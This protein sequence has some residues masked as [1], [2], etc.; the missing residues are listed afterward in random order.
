MP[1]CVLLLLLCGHPLTKEG[2]PE[3]F[4]TQISFHLYFSCPGVAVLKFR[5]LVSNLVPLH[6]RQAA[7]LNGIPF[8]FK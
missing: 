1:V 3:L 4:A 8:L 6:S 7:P 2:C 5:M